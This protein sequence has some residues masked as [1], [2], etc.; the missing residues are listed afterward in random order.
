MRPIPG[1]GVT[2]T[3]KGFA[4]LASREL[5]AISSRHFGFVQFALAAL[6]SPAAVRPP[7]EPRSVISSQAISGVNPGG[8]ETA[9]KITKSAAAQAWHPT[10]QYLHRRNETKFSQQKSSMLS[11]GIRMTRVLCGARPV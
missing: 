1:A 9:G 7:V 3:T 8:Y 11:G 4:P 2:R 5:H 6:V 10:R